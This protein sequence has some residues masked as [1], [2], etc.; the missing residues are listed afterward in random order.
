MGTC[1]N[2]HLGGAMDNSQAEDY[3]RLAPNSD[4]VP[5]S[6]SKEQTTVPIE[7][8]V[9]SV[10]FGRFHC[11]VF[12]ICGLG[13]MSDA[14][15]GSVLSFL[16][17]QLRNDWNIS[18]EEEGNLGSVSA[19]GQA[20]GALCFGV[21]GDRFGRRPAFTISVGLSAAFGAG[22]ALAPSFHWMLL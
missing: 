7:G 11:M 18:T 15:E 2:P 6:A 14:A 10:G 22:S 17:P 16:L 9:E 8:L 19:L 1:T 13:W 4:A 12:I 20:L 21:L 5:Q 3:A